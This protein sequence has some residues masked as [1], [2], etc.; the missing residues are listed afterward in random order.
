MDDF[1]IWGENFFNVFV[2][3][4]FQLSGGFVLFGGE[5]AWVLSAGEAFFSSD[6]VTL[7]KIRGQKGQIFFQLINSGFE[8]IIGEES[9]GLFFIKHGVLSNK[10]LFHE[11]FNEAIL[12]ICG[13]VM[14][15]DGI[16]FV[17]KGDGFLGGKFVE[18]KVV[19]DLIYNRTNKSI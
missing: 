16:F 10:F 3:A 11:N 18:L 12:K 17:Q 5:P 14:E 6:F 13:D 9:I 4:E 15:L 7:F 19:S 8:K 2:E 1:V